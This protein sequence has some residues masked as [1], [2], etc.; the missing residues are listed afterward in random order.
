MRW[1]PPDGGEIPNGSEV[2]QPARSVPG[3]HPETYLSASTARADCAP[4]WPCR[5]L[6]LDPI[7]D[8][9]RNPRLPN[10]RGAVGWRVIGELPPHEIFGAYGVEVADLIERSRSLTRDH[11]ERL[12]AAWDDSLDAT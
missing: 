7:G 12:M 5:L 10:A 11:A 3:D 4:G 8:V 2:W 1:A 9:V 6:V